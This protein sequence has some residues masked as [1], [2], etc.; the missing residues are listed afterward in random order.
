MRS[1]AIRTM[2]KALH[3]GRKNTTH[4]IR[5]PSRYWRTRGMWEV[6]IGG[7]GGSYCWEFVDRDVIGLEGVGD[8]LAFRSR[9]L[10]DAGP[11]VPAFFPRY[12]GN[13]LPGWSAR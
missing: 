6:G 8:G 3:L 13:L 11:S 7:E 2:F 1:E 9:T 10:S 12:A 4:S 5:E